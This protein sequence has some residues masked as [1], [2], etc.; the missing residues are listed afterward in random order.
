MQMLCKEEGN[1][2]FS[3][4]EQAKAKNKRRCD[5]NTSVKSGHVISWQ[6]YTTR[7]ILPNKEEMSGALGW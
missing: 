3:F 7:N 6:K 5:G 4:G 1:R 2:K